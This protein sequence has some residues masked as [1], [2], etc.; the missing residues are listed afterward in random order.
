MGS[1]DFHNRLG[2]Q[3]KGITTDKVVLQQDEIVQHTDDLSFS[4]VDEKKVLRKMDVRLIP[5]LALLYLLSFLDVSQPRPPVQRSGLVRKRSKISGTGS[6]QR[7]MLTVM[8]IAWKH[9]QRQ[10][11]RS[12]QGPWPDWPSI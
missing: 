6:S 8:P 10:N 1:S 11:S 4:N 9:W 5:V 2:N 12:Y 7:T 3:E